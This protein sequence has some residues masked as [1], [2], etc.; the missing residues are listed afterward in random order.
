MLV[1]PDD[2]EAVVDCLRKL[3]CEPETLREEKQ[4]SVARAQKATWDVGVEKLLAVLQRPV[5]D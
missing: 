5:Q 4:R 2:F 1:D 3:A